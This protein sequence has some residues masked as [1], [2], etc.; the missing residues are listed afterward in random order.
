MKKVLLPW[1][2]VCL[3]VFRLVILPVYWGN[4]HGVCVFCRVC[5]CRTGD[6]QSESGR[7]SVGRKSINLCHGI[8]Y[9]KGKVLIMA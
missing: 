9:W 2:P 1:A 6:V 5:R 3:C 7:G 4:S 8:K